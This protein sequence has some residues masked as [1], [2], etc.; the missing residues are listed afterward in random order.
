MRSGAKAAKTFDWYMKNSV[1]FIQR[2]QLAVNA[3]TFQHSAY[4]LVLQRPA[5]GFQVNMKLEAVDKRNPILIRVATII[6]KDDHRI[7]V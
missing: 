4:G 2:S 7:K 3:L 1:H 5:H 6:D